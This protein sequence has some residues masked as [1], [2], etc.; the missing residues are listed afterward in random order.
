[1][2]RL[3]AWC[4]AAPQHS[5]QRGHLLHEVLDVDVL[6][7]PLASAR[8]NALPACPEHILNDAVRDSIESGIALAKS[9]ELYDEKLHKRL[10]STPEDILETVL[11]VRAQMGLSLM[12]TGSSLPSEPSGAAT[13]RGAGRG[14]RGRGRGRGGEGSRLGRA[15]AKKRT[16]KPHKGR[17]KAEDDDSD[18]SSA[19]ALSDLSD[20]PTEDLESRHTSEDAIQLDDD[21]AQCAEKFCSCLLL[22]A[23]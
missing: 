15:V 5:R 12:A 22:F 16:P 21:A 20:I 9:I 14:R 13:T 8:A 23:L 7:E 6:Q 2:L 19:V 1:M 10:G 17:K 3:K 18:E 11:E 4:L